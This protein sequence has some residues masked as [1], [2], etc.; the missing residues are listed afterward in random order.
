ML[1]T[2][3]YSVT[4]SDGR[5][6][7]ISK[8]NV[9]VKM[10]IKTTEKTNIMTGESV[11]IINKPE[12]LELSDCDFY[13]HFSFLNNIVDVDKFDIL[14]DKNDVT[15]SESNTRAIQKFD[16]VIVANT[17]KKNANVNNQTSRTNTVK[18]AMKILLN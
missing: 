4:M 10:D 1:V 14:M 8:Q 11:Q 2:W 5:I 17:E 16:K 12:F 3:S 18:P 13:S 15:H 7:V 9:L 6:E